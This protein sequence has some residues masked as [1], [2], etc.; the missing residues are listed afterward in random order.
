ME[1]ASHLPE[2]KYDVIIIGAGPAGL[3]AA[4]YTSSLKLRTLVFEGPN[5]SRLQWAHT[6][7]NYPGFP[8]GIQGGELLRRVREQAIKFG[9]EIRKGN[10]LAA[11]LV[12]EVKTVAT[13]DTSLTAR[14]V[15]IATG[16]QQKRTEVPGEDK[17]LGAGVSYCAI[18]DGPLF[19]GR[20]VAVIG[21]GS[22]AVE[23]AATLSRIA[24]K[25]YLVSPSGTFRAGD[26]ELRKAEEHRVEVLK[27][28]KVKAIDGV[29]SVEVLRL[30]DQ[31]G[32]ERVL[33]VHGVFIVSS[34]T[35]LTK[36]LS[37][38]G[39]ETDEKGCIK[40]NSRMQ[41]NIDGVYAAGDCT[42]GGL[43]ASVGVGEGAKAA[44]AVLARLREDAKEQQDS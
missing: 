9:A 25:T 18:C 42:C 12:G 35:P 40:V 5:P 36:I 29:R 20:I 7:S 41:T 31:K 8:E 34:M 44:L 14:T 3:T 13:Q 32:D 37:K 4:I 2:V 1:H 28:S 15:I 38:G 17:F 27:G 6:V 24:S 30:T 21:E 16:I 26:E 33:R 19:R 43:Q 10:V 22:E 11:D 39:L 23:D